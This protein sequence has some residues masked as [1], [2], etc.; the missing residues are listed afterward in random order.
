M[1]EIAILGATPA[2][3][4]R[5]R[6]YFP[7]LGR[8]G[9]ADPAEMDR[10]F[11]YGLNNPL[12]GSDPSGDIWEFDRDDP[13]NPTVKWVPEPG[14]PNPTVTDYIVAA[15]YFGLGTPSYEALQSHYVRSNRTWYGHWFLIGDK[16]D[17]TL[18]VQFN[19]LV[20]GQSYVR[21]AWTVL[22][23]PLP[24][25]HPSDFQERIDRL[26]GIQLSVGASEARTYY[27]VIGSEVGRLFG[28][29]PAAE[30]ISGVRTSAETLEGLNR[31][32]VGFEAM[33]GLSG[34]ALSIAGT[35]NYNPALWGRRFAP[36]PG[37]R[38]VFEYPGD[39]L[40]ESALTLEGGGAPRVLARETNKEAIAANRAAA[41]KGRGKAPPGTWWDE[42]PFASSR[43]GG[44]GSFVRAVP[45]WEQRMQGRLLGAFYR[46]NRIGQGDLYLVVVVRF[47]HGGTG[48]MI[49]TASAA[50]ISVPNR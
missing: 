49:T 23:T 36:P 50:G 16:D 17:I 12:S 25:S 9:Q 19:K 8:F 28:F 46:S 15:Q 32:G 40:P 2:M 38:A 30:A 48:I 5:A 44:V 37:V 24:P 42:F 18:G 20:Y 1:A 34:S 26:V 43:Q 27:N 6:T 35:L 11:L 47:P 3:H 39:L 45:I 41:L 21:Y 29:T 22:S 7:E 10:V 14:K 4:Y 13:Y 31:W 33:A